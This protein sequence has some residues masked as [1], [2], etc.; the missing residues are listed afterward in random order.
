MIGYMSRNP[1][2]GAQCT[3]LHDCARGLFACAQSR[4]TKHGLAKICLR[5]SA[6]ILLLMVTT[7]EAKQSQLKER[8]L[9]GCSKKEGDLNDYTSKFRHCM[10]EEQRVQLVSH[11]AL[12]LKDVLCITAKPSVSGKALSFAWQC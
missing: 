6:K 10:G 4:N 2:F 8:T 7:M 9:S 5:S 3:I 1:Y 12:R 11:S